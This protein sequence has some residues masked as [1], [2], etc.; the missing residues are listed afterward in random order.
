MSSS[1]IWQIF[2]SSFST[3][4]LRATTSR[5]YS[6]ILFRRQLYRDPLDINFY[7]I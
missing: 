6:H 3:E 4:H 7:D 1:E 2:K 5:I